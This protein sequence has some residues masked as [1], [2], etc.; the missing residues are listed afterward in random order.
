MVGSMAIERF[1]WTRHAERKR[2][3]RLI[4]R[5]TVERAI[6]DGHG[7]RAINR[8][9][10]DWLVRGSLPDGRSFEVVYDHPASRDPAAVVIVSVWDCDARRR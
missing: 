8:G 1:I 6:R 7:N 5:G 4:D 3:R 10:A 9:Q 2:A